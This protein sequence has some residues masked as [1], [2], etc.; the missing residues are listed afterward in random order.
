MRDDRV[1]SELNA[2]KWDGRA[3]N[4]DRPAFDFFRHLQK[5][6]VAAASPRSGVRFLD[7]G[8]GTGW[9]VRYASELAGD[10]EFVG[11]DLSP[12]MLEKARE[13]ARECNT[14]RFARANAESLPFDDGAFDIVICTMSFH[15]YLNPPR[16][17]AEA[18]RV[19]APQGC[20]YLLDVASDGPLGLLIELVTRSTEREHVRFHSTRE[21]R[22]LFEEAG[23]TPVDT[24]RLL[25]PVKLQIG[26][27]A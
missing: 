6:V 4:F 26:R 21:L 11:V 1:H 20:Y 14:V 24:K 17:L 12:K 10:G 8:C 2:R 3:E 9:A 27:R 16:A 23:L 22:S 13:S 19:L 15:H 25:G 5:K 7:I 18:R